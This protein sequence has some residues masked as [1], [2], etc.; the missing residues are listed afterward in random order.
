MT[1]RSYLLALAAAVLWLPDPGL[2]AQSF[3]Y[4]VDTTFATAYNPNE[5]CYNTA[6]RKV[7][8]ATS[9]TVLAVIDAG[10]NYAYIMASWPANPTYNSANDRVYVSGGSYV[11]VYD[12]QS[13]ALDTSLIFSEGYPDLEYSP[14]NNLLY[15]AGMGLSVLD[16]ATDSILAHHQGNYERRLFLYRPTNKILAVH[17]WSDSLLVAQGTSF[18][19]SLRVPG[20]NDQSRLAANEARGKIYIS[21]PGANQVAIL[22]AGSHALLNTVGVAAGPHA[23]A[24]SPVSDEIYVACHYSDSLTVI[25]GSDDSVST[26]YLGAAGDSTTSIIYNAFVQ[27]IYYADENSGLVGIVNPFTKTVE[28]ALGLPAGA[29]AHPVALI[30]GDSGRVFVANSWG[31]SISVVGWSEDTKPYILWTEPAA[32]EAGV[33][34]NRSL[35]VAFSEAIEPSSLAFTC[36]P[37]PGGWSVRWDETFRYLTL[38]H[39]H[40]VPGMPH[41]FTVTQASDPWGNGLVDTTGS[42]PNPWS[43]WVRAADTVRHD[44]AGG[45]Y[46]IISVPLAPYDSSAAVNFGD[47]LGAYGQSGWRLFGYDPLSQANVETPPLRPGRGY[48]LSSVRSATLDAAGYRLP[49]ENHESR[50]PLAAGWNLIGSPYDSLISIADCSVIDTGSLYLPF[51][52]TLANAAVRQRLWVYSD[53]TLDLRN[54]GSWDRDTLTPLVPTHML[55]PWQGYAAYATRPCSL[56]VRTILNKAAKAPSQGPPAADVHWSLKLS[57]GSGGETDNGVALGVSPR[58]LPGYDRLDGE[59]P[60][61]VSDAVRLL[62]PQREW[63]PGTWHEYAS[64]FR[65]GADH[66]EWPVSLRL[67]D[68]SAEAVLSY[69]LEGGLPPGQRL[70]LVERDNLKAIEIAGAG[71]AGFTGDRELAVVLTNRGIGELPF[72]PLAFELSAPRPNPSIQTARINYQI[73]KAGLVKLAV[74]NALGQWVRTITEGQ[75]APG[76]YTASW[77]GRGQGTAQAPPG[78]YFVRLQAEGLQAVRR[79][80]RVR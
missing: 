8:C 74:Y 70:Y 62:I 33:P 44:W 27:R 48:W 49:T 77:D 43:F 26:V 7:Y 36:S 67:A 28:A 56:Y 17:G 64:D 5:F 40:F 11:Y 61:A 6:R 9:D 16:G 57:A 60:P 41:T 51:W 25:R 69:R 10:L 47:D 68:Q 55:T 50:I 42:A 45:R 65:P 14:G 59:K 71:Q 34:F 18:I 19:D 20:M 29:S 63:G 79:L 76:Y 75:R 53:T 2:E 72:A 54:N 21:L 37:N 15:A 12:G 78:V 3:S 23:M 32:G 46:R 30:E 38:E 13:N 24:Y 52:D 73:T 58:A 1:R 31:S 39:N 4:S 80:V 35:T 22:D 66:I